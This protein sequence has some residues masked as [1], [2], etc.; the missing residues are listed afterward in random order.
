MMIGL[1]GIYFELSHPGSIFPGVIGGI[2]LILAFYSF[3]TL[4]V[5]YAGLL[6]ILL[7]V[8][9]FILEI[10][11]QSYGLLSIGGLISLVL[12][13]IMLFEDLRVSLRLL[14]PTVL[15]ICGFFVVVAGLAF[16]AQFKRPM[17]GTE[18]LVGEVGH[19][20]EALGKSA[21]VFV[22]GE[23]WN[24]ISE[25]PLE[26]GQEIVVTKVNGLTLTVTKKE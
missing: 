10:K 7:A 19:V 11:V 18:G 2:S 1:A 4:P 25:E 20:I 8:I 14:I 16:R 26:I 17:T 15:G 23:Y 13:S 21:K 5:N 9:L 24:A 12:G 3:Q 6:L 22:H